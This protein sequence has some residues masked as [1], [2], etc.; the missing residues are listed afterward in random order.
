M[1]IKLDENLPDRLV[2]VL[3]GLGHDVDTVRGERLV[4]RVDPDVWT[5]A[6]AAQRFL[7]TQDL[8]FSDMRRY[9]PGTHAGLLLVRLTRPGRNALFERV[10]AV[11]QT[12][13]VEGWTGCLVVATERKVRIRRPGRPAEY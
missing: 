10:S 13:R 1:N 2:P 3:T 9:V 8:D 11:F 5:A 4:G 7:I 6:Q 12:E